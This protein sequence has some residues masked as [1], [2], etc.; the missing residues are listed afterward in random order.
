MCIYS[1]LDVSKNYINGKKPFCALNKITLAIEK[2]AFCCF[3]G[4]SGSGKT[5]LL[6]ILGLIDNP[7]SGKLIFDSVEMNLKTTK[8]NDYLRLEKIGF[9]F[10]DFKLFPFLSAFEN[11]EYPLKL[12]KIKKEKRIEMVNEVLD[13]LGILSCKNQL[14]SELSGGQQQR[15]GIAR[16]LIKSPKII[17]A[18]EPT[19]NLDSKNA[20]NIISILK[21]LNSDKKITIVYA[22]HD[23]RLF[24]F[25]SVLYKLKDG[26]LV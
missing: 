25:S 11:I 1:L 17:I 23:T 9:I 22:T 18:D 20:G 7:S 5:T 10:Q 24:R 3:A 8:M 6:D 14:P 15:V 16:A 4:P 13:Y 2:G 12:L 19:A 21:R 26:V